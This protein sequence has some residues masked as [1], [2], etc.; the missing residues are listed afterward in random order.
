MK[1]NGE[2]ARNI[3]LNC[4]FD[5]D[6]K[7]LFEAILFTVHSCGFVL[8]CAKEQKGT[9]AIRIKKIVSL[10]RDSKYAIH[11]LSRVSLD[12]KTKLPR[13]NMPLELGL[14]IGAE[15]FGEG[16]QKEKQFV[17]VES[18]KYRVKK[19]ISDIDGQDIISHENNPDLLI[20]KLRDW[21]SDI[22]DVP[23]PSPRSIKLNLINFNLQ[24]PAQCNTFDW[25]PN[26]LTFVEKS[27]LIVGY[28][29]ALRN[30]VIMPP[31]AIGIPVL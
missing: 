14:W 16:I 25:D 13:F 7:D 8:R 30:P 26:N 29:L 10:I 4:P 19:Y 21:L 24:L 3:F 12:K 18:E 2:Y 31:G 11:D 17:V 5:D 6:Y 15:H 20:D 23:V 28:L 27:T 22:S 1:I 9:E